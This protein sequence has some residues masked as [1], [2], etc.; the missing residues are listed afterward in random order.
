MAFA[1]RPLPKVATAH[2]L[3][4]RRLWTATWKFIS[5]K[6]LGAL[7]AAVI[8]V[9]LGVALTA[10]LIAPYDVYE[11][12]QRLQFR[13]PNLEPCASNRL[14]GIWSGVCSPRSAA[15][16]LARARTRRRVARGLGVEL[17]GAG[18]HH[19]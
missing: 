11:I 2:D 14:R 1:T 16:G 9:M 10:E 17:A 3:I 18:A 6:P 13:A 15:E 7:G 12:N 19:R 5:T 8:M 4:G